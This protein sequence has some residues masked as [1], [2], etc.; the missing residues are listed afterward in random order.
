MAFNN[1]QGPWRC[2]LTLALSDTEGLTWAYKR[3]V[4]LGCNYDRVVPEVR[5]LPAGGV[6]SISQLFG[7]GGSEPIKGFIRWL[8]KGSL[9]PK[10]STE[11][12]GRGFKL[13]Q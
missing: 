7:W 4:E 5:G 13:K 8:G 10:G 9:P 6:G 1:R 12:L 3:D 11:W 2:P